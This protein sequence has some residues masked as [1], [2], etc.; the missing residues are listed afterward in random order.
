MASVGPWQRTFTATNKFGSGYV[1][2]PG[3]TYDN[4][5]VLLHELSHNRYM[6]HANSEQCNACDNSCMMANGGGLGKR[7]YNAVHN[8]QVSWG[9]NAGECDKV[10]RNSQ[11]W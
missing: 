11:V 3:D 7:C 9:L 2:L 8:W 5:E 10:C 4:L 6:G 1:W